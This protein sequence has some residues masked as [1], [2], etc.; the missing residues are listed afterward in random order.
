MIVN[1]NSGSFKS[2]ES[3]AWA[4]ALYGHCMAAW[5]IWGH[6]ASDLVPDRKCTWPMI[7]YDQ[8]GFLTCR[9]QGAA[10]TR[11]ST[12]RSRSFSFRNFSTSDVTMEMSTTVCSKVKNTHATEVR[13][14]L[15]PKGLLSSDIPQMN[16]NVLVQSREISVAKE[17]ITPLHLGACHLLS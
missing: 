12:S 6:R 14:R 15:G 5:S 3:A 16:C 13:C 11:T 8:H 9:S 2:N 10:L 17:N 4:D 7:I 1:S